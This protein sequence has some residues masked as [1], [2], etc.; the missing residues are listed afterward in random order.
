MKHVQFVASSN[1]DNLKPEDLTNVRITQDE[2]GQSRE[3]RSSMNC[4]LCEES[5]WIVENP[6][7]MTILVE[8]FKVVDPRA[9][10]NGT[11][12]YLKFP[13]SLL[14]C[15]YT[16]QDEFKNKLTKGTFVQR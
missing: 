15:H 10:I 11:P 5:I 7:R 2:F 1:L 4:C 3:V 14:T 9:Y 16:C 12:D 8:G 13:K 6:G